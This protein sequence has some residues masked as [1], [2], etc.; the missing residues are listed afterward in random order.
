MYEIAKGNEK[1]NLTVMFTF[2]A[3]GNMCPPMV[4]YNYKRIPQHIL[5][6]VPPN[7]GVGRSDTG[8]M[9]AE[10]F[11]EYIANVFHP[12]LI[13][14]NIQFPVILFVDG[15]KSH[16]TY[17]LSNLC[18]QLNIILIAL[19]PNATR[20]LQPADVA[21]FKPLKSGWK[22]GLFEW[23]NEN[24]NCVVT[25][26]D[27]API[28][29]K[30]IKSTVKSEVLIN[31]FRACGLYP[32]DANQI[33][34]KKCLGKNKGV[35]LNDTENSNIP[36][37]TN[38]D[39]VTQLNFKELSDIV[40]VKMVEK[41]KYIHH[42]VETEKHSEEFFI[43]YRL[44]E[45]LKK[46]N[47]DVG[48]NAENSTIQLSPTKSTAQSPDSIVINIESE[49]LKEP[50]YITS[51]SSI[52]E[53]PVQTTTNPVN[54]KTFSITPLESCLVWP[55]TPERKNI[56]MTERVPYVITSKNWKHL[57]EEKENAKRKVEVEKET[58]K[59]LREENK[60]L[61][62]K[63]PTKPIKQK[64]IR[65][66]FPELNKNNKPHTVT[67]QTISF[68]SIDDTNKTDVDLEEADNTS[69]FKSVVE[70]GCCVSCDTDIKNTDLGVE[71][72]FCNNKYH[73]RCAVKEIYDDLKSDDILFICQNCEKAVGNC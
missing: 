57:Y 6:S 9:K 34:F 16:L 42:V 32:W 8:W 21:A 1:E 31:G 65:S 49:L 37:N 18:S 56:R 11:Y 38:T 55:I 15:H 54:V 44:F 64:V 60:I 5:D 28:L 36:K 43:L 46:S 2:N 20:I 10:V 39:L 70:T 26:K 53:T 7:W 4:I 40:G 66:L 73:Q 29:D 14:N 24:P 22:R 30:V 72:N 68:K 25:K 71:C 41:F 58:R 3:V 47:S 48:F 69:L 45:K 35:E 61:K 19:Y 67:S 52:L 63:Q 51:S 62:A 59:R 33:D 12:F 17:Q 13:D 50:T 27:F 23:R